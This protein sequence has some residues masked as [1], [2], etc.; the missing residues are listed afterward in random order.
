MYLYHYYEKTSQP[1]L[2]LSDLSIEEANQIL[3]KIKKQSQT[4]SVQKGKMIT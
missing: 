1:F 4:F 2:N 3:E